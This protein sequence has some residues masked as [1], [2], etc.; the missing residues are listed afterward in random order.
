MGSA[1]VGFLVVFGVLHLLLIA[2][3]IA[4]TLKASI[5]A[6]SKLVWC[7]FLLLLPGVGVLIF[8]FKFRSLK[9]TNDNF[10]FERN[11]FFWITPI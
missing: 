4:N 3:P 5:S 2:V 1:M 7:L 9:I 10:L 11:G 6:T 8:H